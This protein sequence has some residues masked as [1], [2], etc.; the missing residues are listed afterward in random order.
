MYTSIIL[1]A[2]LIIFILLLLEIIKIRKLLKTKNEGLTPIDA[3]DDELYE[4]AKELVINLGKSSPE[5]LQRS[6]NIGYAKSARLQ[7]ALKEKGII[8]KHNS[9]KPR[10]VLL[11]KQNED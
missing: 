5:I 2:I 10:E 11:N 7:E 1:T 9:S 6:F 3:I 4:K 8:G